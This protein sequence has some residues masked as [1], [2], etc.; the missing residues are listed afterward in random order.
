[1]L[2]DK[3]GGRFTYLLRHIAVFSP[4]SR[5]DNGARNIERVLPKEAAGRGAGKGRRFNISF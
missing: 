3:K 5:P 4:V 1:M 2:L